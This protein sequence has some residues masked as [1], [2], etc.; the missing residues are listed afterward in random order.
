MMCSTPL[1]SGFV[2]HINTEPS[3]WE[4]GEGR[5][6][7]GDVLVGGRRLASRRDIPRGTGAVNKSPE[8]LESVPPCTRGD[9]R[10]VV[11]I[12]LITSP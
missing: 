5:Q 3:P 4:G 2:S 10:G 1:G 6:A 7:Q 12:A 8:R 11:G 9:F